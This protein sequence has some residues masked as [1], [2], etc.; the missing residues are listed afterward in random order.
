MPAALR[1]G[2][3]A[4]LG[5]A[6]L[7]YAAVLLAGSALF[8]ALHYVGNTISYDAALEKATT[9]IASER[10]DL[11]YVAGV[12]GRRFEYCQR[13]ATVLGG[14]KRFD[15]SSALVD[16]TL[17]PMIAVGT[18][19]YCERI[20]LLPDNED[21][22][23]VLLKFRYWWGGTAIY[24][25]ALRYLSDAD[26]RE[27][28]RILT[29]FALGAL[30]AAL[31]FL[32]RKAFLAVVPLAVFAS[33]FSGLQYF[34]DAANGL[35]FLLAPVSGSALALAMSR[36]ALAKTARLCCF[37]TGMASSY[38]WL[39]DGHNVLVLAL[40]ALITYFGL[41][42]ASVARRIGESVFRIGL[43]AA[44]FAL[45]YAVGLTVKAAFLQW[46][47]GAPRD[48]ASAASG[49]FLGQVAVRVGRLSETLIQAFA[50]GWAEAPVIRDFTPYWIM[51]PDRVAF[52][53]AVTLISALAFAVALAFAAALFVK[54]AKSLLADMSFIIALI[55]VTTLQFI[56]PDDLPDRSSRYLFMA[57]ALCWSCFLLA[58][59]EAR[60]QWR[61][62]SA[63][64]EEAAAE[65]EGDGASERAPGNRRAATRMRSPN[66]AA[67]F[68]I[69]FP[70]HTA[71]RVFL[72][73]AVVAVAVGVGGG[74][75]LLR[76][77]AAFARETIRGT[78]PLI[79]GPF[80]VYY[81]ENKL[82]YGRAECDEY[83]TA[84]LFFLHLMP[85]NPE[86]LP[87]ERQ[88]YAF[89][90]LRFYFAERKVPYSDGCAAVVNL[91]DYEITAVST[92]QYISGERRFWQ[93]EFNPDE[94]PKVNA[95]E[96]TALLNGAELLAQSEFNVHR[97]RNTLLLTR[98]ACDSAD[99]RPR[100]FL[101]FT[102]ANV[103]D[104]QD[105]RRQSGF[106][107]L[108]FNFLDYGALLFQE[109]MCVAARELPDYP[110]TAVSV[111]QYT[112]EGPV[113]G[114]TIDLT[115]RRPPP[116][117][118]ASA[119][120]LLNG[121]ELL[122]QSEFDIHRN[123][124]TL[125]LTKSSCA[126]EDVLSRFFLHIIPVSQADLPEERRVHGFDNLDFNFLDHGA[127]LLQER[128]CIAT[129]ELPG[130]PAAS[131]RTGQYVRGEGE[132][133]SEA[134]ALR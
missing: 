18:A 84:P 3:R 100:F 102:P 112:N 42:K 69:A 41:R 35:P 26:I 77:D 49:D 62:A 40:I 27:W 110:V 128:R 64:A 11:G 4:S 51:G 48:S 92:G 88:D 111:G 96:M 33:F 127:L 59:R 15:G 65:A 13:V 123:G 104:L 79:H 125:L 14:A 124:N 68:K 130:Y 87:S 32:S 45:C 44:G 29:I 101:H 76:S 55:A 122:A 83:D 71:V 16:A 129:R 67:R 63:A 9:E 74:S 47:A 12:N 82:V 97:N 72:G 10:P 21:V 93:G 57:H 133:W 43:Y 17:L 66:S 54:G 86:D 25:I 53:Q 98:L 113:W 58:A 132:I 115:R 8:F 52:G 131:I 78:Q 119:T 61:G 117:D 103:D 20:P 38:L 23:K 1:S 118:V 108:D 95:S 31:W 73:A 28:T 34:S 36:P 60:V 70:K 126:N 2:R 46:A 19:D 75:L 6:A 22:Y 85:A 37:V 7:L 109:G 105:E 81:A 91:P 30:A 5:R 116:I 114:L 107:N 134:I 106:D 121:A 24:A 99:V 80:S 39:L 120:A 50:N 56:M 94:P 89:D 90:N